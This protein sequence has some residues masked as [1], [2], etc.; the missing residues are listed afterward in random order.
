MQVFKA[1]FMILKKNI[2]TA[3]IFTVIFVAISFG[4]ATSSDGKDSFVESRITIAVIDEDSS[5]ASKALTAFFAKKHEIKDIGTDKEKLTEE[6]YWGTVD[7]VLIIRNGFNDALEKGEISRDLLG[8]YK[9][10]ES[11]SA[12]YMRT[13][14]NEYVKTV[15]ACTASGKSYS[16]ALTS[17]AEAL[18]RDTEVT[19]AEDKSGTADYSKDFSVYFQYMPYILISV[20]LS[21]LGIVLSSLNKKDVRY[22]TEC[23]SLS[24]RSS[25][26]QIFAASAVFVLVIWLIYMIA[27]AVMYGGIY[28]GVSWYAVLNSLIFTL[29]SASIAIFISSLDVEENVF[30]ILTQIIGLGMSFL[31]GV[32]VPLSILSEGVQTVSRFLPAYWY[33]KA[34]D[35]IVGRETFD[36]AKLAGYMGIQL[37][38]V[39][40]LLLLTL[41]VRRSRRQEALS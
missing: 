35:M 34:N 21:T 17:A 10:R 20:M 14:L 15:E 3:I 25:T 23:S 5:E 31:C 16:E 27:G 4:I 7:Y 36:G 28:K 39:A 32:F 19:F 6:L 40:V 26:L 38:F 18:S 30:S 12:A 33:I 8:E 13:E 2:K 24:P 1:F 37:A 9:V 22:R 29:V 41:V 11:Y